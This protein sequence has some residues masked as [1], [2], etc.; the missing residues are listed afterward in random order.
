MDIIA[1]LLTRIRNGGAAAHEKVDVPC[2]NVKI[3]ICKILKDEGYIKS[4]KE[5]KDNRQNII[6]VI[7]KYNDAGEHAIK[8]ISRVSRSGLRRYAGVVDIPRIRNGMGIAIMSTSKGI[9]TDRE[10]R[11]LKTGG[12]VMCYV[13]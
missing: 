13:W 5:I 12:E 4:Y 8:N 3:A 10:A 6:R 2:S 7:L 1:N 9:V 11:K